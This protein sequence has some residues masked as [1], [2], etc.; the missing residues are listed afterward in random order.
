MNE[1]NI[2]KAL[3]T[4]SKGFAELALAFTDEGKVVVASSAEDPQ[5]TKTEGLIKNKNLTQEE[6]DK[7]QEP[8]I[9]FASMTLAKLKD[10]AKDLGLEPKGTKTKIIKMIEDFENTS[11]GEEEKEE[12]EAVDVEDIVEGEDDEKI[13]ELTEMLKEYEEEELKDLLLEY[14]IEPVGKKNAMIDIIIQNILSGNIELD[15]D[16]EDGDD[17]TDEENDVDVVE[18]DSDAETEE[19]NEEPISEERQNT[20]EE[21]IDSIDLED[22]KTKKDMI[23]KIIAFYDLDVKPKDFEDEY[24]LEDS[25]ASMLTMFIDDDGEYHEESDPYYID[26]NPYCCGTPL[27]EETLVCEVCGT[28]YG[29]E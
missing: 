24:D 8:Q 7:M 11:Q 27:D 21:L 19:E 13:T 25:L 4:I 12:L 23:K 10:Y 1:T 6:F 22:A 20:L 3:V 14:D 16:G 2:S 9:D 18:V 28:E 5:E 29:D 17:T 26:E 15:T